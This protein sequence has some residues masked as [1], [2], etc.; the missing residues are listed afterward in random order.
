MVARLI[1]KKSSFTATYGRG[2]EKGDK[3][4]FMIFNFMQFSYRKEENGILTACS[5]ISGLLKHDF[6]LGTSTAA[7]LDA[8][9][10]ISACKKDFAYQKPIRPHITYKDTN[11]RKA[12]TAAERLTV[13]IRINRQSCSPHLHHFSKI[14]QAAWVLS[15]TTPKGPPKI[16]IGIHKQNV[17]NKASKV[18]AE[19]AALKKTPP[20]ANLQLDHSQY[21][22]IGRRLHWDEGQQIGGEYWHS[23]RR[24][25]MYS[26]QKLQE[27]SVVQPTSADEKD[28]LDRFSKM[29]KH[30]ALALLLSYAVAFPD[31]SNSPKTTEPVVTTTGGQIKGSVLKSRLGKPIY[32]FRGVRYAKAPVNELRF[33]PPVP[34]EKWEGVYDAT[35]DGP[36]C[37]KLL[38]IPS[39]KT[40]YS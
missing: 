17:H 18:V 2:V 1:Q 21:H 29:I 31:G 23:Y 25:L 33:K 11:L 20:H 38:L 16:T 37:H 9:V 36:L 39:Q 5:I 28:H 34:I 27:K 12:I 14:L 13:T 10:P 40:V 15:K 22:T 26:L 32:S 30:V 3:V 7:Y 4:T 35:K 19:A 6:R 24:V 8:N